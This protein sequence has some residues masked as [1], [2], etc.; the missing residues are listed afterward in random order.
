MNF[1]KTILLSAFAIVFRVC[2]TAQAQHL[3]WDPGAEKN[4]TCV[5]GQITVLATHSSTYYCG[6]NWHPGEAAGGYCGIQHNS[7]DEKRT[8][9]SI[10]DTSP[11]LHPRVTF[12]DEKTQHGRFGGEGEGGHTHMLWPWKIG[13]TFEYYLTKSPGE[14]DS[15]DVKYYVFDRS[16]GKWIHSATISC[17]NGG[18]AEIGNFSGG[19][20]D[21]FLE[22]FS[23]ED[24]QAPRLA[25]YRL[26]IGT[27]P[28]NLTEV[29]HAGGD[30]T[31][32]TL[33]NCFFLGG[34]SMENLQA[35]FDKLEKDYGKPVIATKEKS[36]GP[37]AEEPID[38]QVLS[39]LKNLPTAPAA[40]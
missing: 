7:G 30:G 20:M 27:K 10:W 17:P 40:K 1:T 6:V 21:A 13:E 37:I 35:V 36:P 38:K 14:N 12:A 16:T 22:N 39:A 4:A 5:Y 23:G 9:F 25:I 8:I 28:D 2:A 34:G 33:H 29:I 11:Q 18:H 32:G 19:G 26:W 24:K 31:W 15:T 3:W